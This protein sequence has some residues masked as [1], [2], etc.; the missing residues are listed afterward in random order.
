MSLL[1]ILVDE[2]WGA[3]RGWWRIYYTSKHRIFLT[4]WCSAIGFSGWSFSALLWPCVRRRWSSS[5]LESERRWFVWSGGRL[6]SESRTSTL[7]S[8]S[9]FRTFFL[10]WWP[11]FFFI[12][13]LKLLI[14]LVPLLSLK[15][16]SKWDT[17]LLF[18][19]LSSS[20]CTW[21]SSK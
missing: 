4:W 10:L 7:S 2:R 17:W 6:R 19:P 5:T 8:N 16:S 9:C 1:G 14:L 21:R 18:L 13:L 12:V 3:G 15:L 11:D 20:F